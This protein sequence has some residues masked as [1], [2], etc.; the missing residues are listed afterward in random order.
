[1]DINPDRPEYFTF[2]AGNTSL[3]LNP[4]AFSD[5]CPLLCTIEI[6]WKID[7]HDGTRIPV[8]PAAYQTGQPSAF[9][10]DIRFLGD[11]VGY[12]NTIHTITFWIVD[13]SGN[14][15]DPQTQTI[16]IKPRPTIIGIN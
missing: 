5:N 1:M 3:D 10:S 13:C 4:S 8:L 16:T 6:R 15:S 7:M 9:G 11:G 12:T 2:V 14:V